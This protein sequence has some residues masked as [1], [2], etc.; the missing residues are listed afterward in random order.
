MARFDYWKQFIKDQSLINT[1][2]SRHILYSLDAND[3]AEAEKRI[4]FEFPKE[5]NVFYTEIGYGFLCKDDNSMIDRIMDPFSVADFRL[6]QGIYET[7]ENVD[8]FSSKNQFVFFEVNEDSFIHLDLSKHDNNGV[9]PIY[10][11]DLKIADS[12]Q[13]FLEKMDQRTDYYL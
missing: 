11:F 13:E 2:Q 6:K 1:G 8:L 9:H 3:I 10:Y 5:L 12:L 7:D 4:G